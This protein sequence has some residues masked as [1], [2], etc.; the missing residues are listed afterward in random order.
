MSSVAEA[1]ELIVVSHDNEDKAPLPSGF[2]E[3]SVDDVVADEDL[4]WDDAGLDTTQQSDTQH[5]L[6]KG[7]RR[8]GGD[9]SLAEA[10]ASIEVPQDR[11]WLRRVWAYVGP[12]Y[13]IAVG[14]Q[15]THQPFIFSR[16]RIHGCGKLVHEHC[17]GLCV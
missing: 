10:F 1:A 16:S 15:D 14:T 13:C 6:L 7:W 12:G 9:P 2:G 11:G 3:T 5:A 17:C 4:A 8:E